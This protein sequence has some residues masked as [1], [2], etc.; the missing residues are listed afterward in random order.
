L[1]I[2]SEILR[3]ALGL[4]DIFDF[5]ALHVSI[6]SRNIQPGDLFFAIR[7]GNQFAS[8][9]IEN[10]A[11]ASIIDNKAFQ[12]NKT[13]LVKDSLES[14][15]KLGSYIKHMTN[16]K[17]VLG[18]TGSVGK[19]TTKSWLNKILNHSYKSFASLKN[20]NTIYGI[21]ISLT[22]LEPNTDFCI[23]E[24]GSNN[25]GEI[26]ELSKY[27]T[28]DIGIITNIYESHI[29]KFKNRAELADEKI[30]IIDGIKSDR[31]LIYDGDSD[32][33]Q[34]IKNSIK[35]TISVGF[36]ND[37]DIAILE[38]NACFVKIKTPAGKLEYEIGEYG[39]HFVYISACVIAA[40]FALN[41]DVKNFLPLIR[42]LKPEKG[43]GEII[44]C[45]SLSGRNLKLIDDS[46]NAS[47]SSMFAAIDAFIANKYTGHKTAILGQMM[48]LNKYEEYY[49]KLLAD[50]LM[51]SSI[52]LIFFI[53]NKNLKKCFSKITNIEL[54]EEM[55]DSVIKIILSKIDL[56]GI[57]L[58]K[59]SRSVGLDKF[60]QTARS[61]I[62]LIILIICRL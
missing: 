7:R 56:E 48:E 50:K 4:N 23:M 10:G 42:D 22:E 37:C 52:E 14:L 49:H 51:Y 43:R 41:L 46:Y 35:N 9:A 17:T 16:P 3:Q 53:G 32:F 33:K 15:K 59:G 6:D 28:P 36:N 39:K 1:K 61:I 54:F 8:K 57:V 21:P 31:I 27:L 13:I 38:I 45:R 30:S 62:S 2:T 34:Q 26:S 5:E 29:G 20:Y 24:I 25:P 11:V 12:G 55:T 44:N 19:T 60:V 47:P 18:I 40:L 58:V